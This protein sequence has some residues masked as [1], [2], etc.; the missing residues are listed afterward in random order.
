MVAHF[1][2]PRAEL[3][4][5]PSKLILSLNAFLPED[6]RVMEVTRCRANFHARYN[7]S[8]KQYRYYVWNHRAMNPLLRNRAWQVPLPLDIAA[9]RAAARVFVGKHDFKS[10]AAT[11]P[12]KKKTTVRTL[13]RCEIQ[14][15]GPL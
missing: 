6:I 10:L 15:R 1:E 8:G 13:T 3:K 4:I 14:R 11:H 12:T 9:M 5:L 2:V 7:A